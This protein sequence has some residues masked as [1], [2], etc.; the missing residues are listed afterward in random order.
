MDGL[1][2]AN[3]SRIDMTDIE[4]IRVRLEITHISGV[5]EHLTHRSR[6]EI[7]LSRINNDL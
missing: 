3:R 7:L 2:A 6:A 5:R 4:Q 1:V